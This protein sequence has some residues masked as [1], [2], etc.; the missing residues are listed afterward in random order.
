MIF[1]EELSLKLKIQVEYKNILQFH[2]SF[3]RFQY[4]DRADHPFA[5]FLYCKKSATPHGIY[6]QQ[7]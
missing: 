7:V 3:D 6:I 4:A 2:L 5:E 1:W